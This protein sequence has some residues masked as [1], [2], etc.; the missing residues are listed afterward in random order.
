M[1]VHVANAKKAR[2]DAVVATRNVARDAARRS[3]KLLKK[4][5]KRK[6]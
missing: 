5:N 6:R 4:K 2:V 3:R 1:D